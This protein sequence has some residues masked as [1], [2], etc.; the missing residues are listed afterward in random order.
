M[1]FSI[2]KRSTNMVFYAKFGQDLKKYN[3]F[4]GAFEYCF[5]LM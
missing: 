4:G 5:I 2:K 1:F 3:T